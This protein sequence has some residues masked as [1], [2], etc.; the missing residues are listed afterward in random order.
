MKIQFLLPLVA[1]TFSLSAQTPCSPLP[2]KFGL[3]V[4]AH[5]YRSS[6]EGWLTEMATAINDATGGGT[7]TFTIRIRRNLIGE[8]VLA[9]G[10]P[11]IDITSVGRAIVLVDWSAA[12][13]GVCPPYPG[14]LPAVPTWKIGDLVF[15]HLFANAAN[16]AYPIEIP[17]HLIGH[18]RG[19]SV[20]SRLAWDLAAYGVWVDQLTT[21]DP[22][23]LDCPAPQD[24]DWPVEAWD[25]VIFADNYYR[26]GGIT[27]PNGQPVTGATNINLTDVITSGGF[28]GLHTDVHTYYHG[29][30]EGYR[31]LPFTVAGRTVQAEW[32]DESLTPYRPPRDTTGFYFSLIRDGDRPA[33]GLHRDLNL[34]IG[35][36]LPV[37]LT[38]QAWP[39]ISVRNLSRY[40]YQA[41]ERINFTWYYQDADSGLNVEF[42]L[43]SD[44]NP[45]NNAGSSCVSSFAPL[46]RSS[47]DSIL[48]GMSFWDTDT[49]DVGAFYLLAKVSDTAGRVRY[50]YLLHP[51]TV[52]AVATSPNLTVLSVSGPTSAVAGAPV[53]VIY[54]V[55]NLG[56]AATG[57]FANRVSLATSTHGTTLRLANFA[58]ASL[59]PNEQ[60][61]ETKTFNVPLNIQPNSYYVTVFADTLD[62]VNEA[63]ENNN[64]GSTAPDRI[65]ISVPTYAITTSASP[66]GSGTTTGDGNY[67]AGT[68]VSVV[69][70]PASGH[71]FVNWTE[72]GTVVSP[73]GGYSFVANAN[74]S[75]TANFAP[76]GGPYILTIS[77]VNGSVARDPSLGSY[78]AASQVTITPTPNAGYYFS[79]WSGDV[80]GNANPL[81]VT[82]DGN[83]S[84]TANFSLI[85]SPVLSV[86]ATTLDIGS[87][88]GIGSFL[89]RNDGDG[90]LSWSATADQP[91]ISIQPDSGNITGKGEENRVVFSFERNSSTSFRSA[92]I[93]VSAKGASE[94]P[95]LITVRQGPDTCRFELN[96][97]SA[98]FDS[99]RPTNGTFNVMTRSECG[100]KAVAS[101]TWI[102]TSSSGTGN[103]MVSY[104][105]DE[106]PEDSV[107]VGS[108]IVEG[109]TFLVSQGP[110]RAPKF[111]WVT[112][113][114]GDKIVGWKVAVDSVGNT[115]VIGALDGRVRVGASDLTSAGLSDIFVAKFDA[116]GR[117]NWVRQIGGLDNETP[118]GIAVD[119][120]GDCYVT[121]G[122]KGTTSFEDQKLTS[123]G[124]TDVFTAKY[125]S[126]GSLLWVRH[127]GGPNND[128]PDNTNGIAVDQDGNVYVTGSFE[129]SA[130]F[131][132]TLLSAVVGEGLFLVKYDSKG[133]IVWI[134]QSE[135]PEGK[136]SVTAVDVAAD[137]SGNSYVTGSLV[138]TVKLGDASI[139]NT[140]A[141]T[142]YLAKFDPSG[143]SVWI[144]AGYG[145]GA[146]LSVDVDSSGNSYITGVFRK[147]EAGFGDKALPGSGEDDIFIAKY[148][149]GGELQ[150]AKRPG[151]SYYDTG[152]SISVDSAGNSYVAGFLAP[153]AKFD[154]QVPQGF[155]GL[156]IFVAKYNTSGGVIWTKTAGG[157]GDNV[158]YGIAA[159]RA[160]NLYVTGAIN[161]SARFDQQTASGKLFV[162]RLGITRPI[163]KIV[164]PLD[165]SFH[166]SVPT[167][168]ALRYTL[169]FKNALNDASWGEIQ[170]I[171][172]DGSEREFMDPAV[173]T[174][175]R[176]YRMRVE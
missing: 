162:A 110:V 109:Q 42:S 10:N 15:T 102:H 140:G 137:A 52:A 150:W 26:I 142:V 56:T 17:I 89:V 93:R 106:H 117:V 139:S 111:A 155:G 62:E 156:D 63:D 99:G 35:L 60:R 30:V 166:V 73:S 49:S 171:D 152:W 39:N 68:T 165:Q 134:S 5:G 146:G 48:E 84:I 133:D 24:S 6:S 36:R 175:M 21:L 149:S 77:A 85:A 86:S 37:D 80:S 53:S 114:D 91:W 66:P 127:G 132:S 148:D 94:S 153:S 71:S 98:T 138:G 58:M 174:P 176:F 130:T 143:K 157:D 125:S 64:I 75:L 19:G 20:M 18:S 32:Y 124:A 129:A 115:F 107:R 101:E 7:P 83:R 108:I 61:T 44:T 25:N 67:S 76:V 118:G 100:W 90:T 59:A 123:L 28:A 34:G 2:A 103:G 88:S 120:N 16:G 29:T 12:D 164:R 161:G 8:A 159:D 41:G 31:I 13:E 163:I 169:E 96:P 81:I 135:S 23:P 69:A 11:P 79:G 47:S 158:A 78:A 151:S 40:N 65:T 1:L 4:L 46:S 168:T 144:H 122:F 54:T 51:V 43:D 154:S 113:A 74:R 14:E 160:G 95:K 105:I 70:T 55:K 126:N 72:G 33:A 136:A 57:P 119:K 170:T 116:S 82:M 22:H 9:P 87:G 141:A 97:T 50:N 128:S 121:G 38:G 131:A 104:T 27:S 92:I 172:G 112:T 173:L 167:E 3:T 145:S 45:F 147:G